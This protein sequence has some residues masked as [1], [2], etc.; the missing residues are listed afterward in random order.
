[1]IMTSA[2]LQDN[3]WL[4]CVTEALAFEDL[5]VY[6]ENNTQASAVITMTEGDIELVSYIKG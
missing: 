3:Q 4:M 1:M 2:A 5:D 6:F